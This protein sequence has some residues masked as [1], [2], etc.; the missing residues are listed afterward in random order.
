MHEELEKAKLENDDE[1]CLEHSRL[2]MDKEHLLP[3]AAQILDSYPNIIKDGESF[4]PILSLKSEAH[5]KI[6]G[7]M[8]EQYMYLSNI[9]LVFSSFLIDLDLFSRWL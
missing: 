9:Q 4:I 2:S 7:M 8:K 1:S 6:I 5:A 3:C